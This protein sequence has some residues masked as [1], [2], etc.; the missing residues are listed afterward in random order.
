[1]QY[2]MSAF[3]PVAD[4]LAWEDTPWVSGKLLLHRSSN[5]FASRSFP[6]AL[7]LDLPCRKNRALVEDQLATDAVGL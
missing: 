2:S 7:Q 1:M 3:Y 5:R 6:I 4:A